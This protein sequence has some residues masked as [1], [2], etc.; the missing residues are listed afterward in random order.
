ML[1]A[2]VAYLASAALVDRRR[3]SCVADVRTPEEYAQ[4]KPFRGGYNARLRRTMRR[5]RR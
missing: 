4:V 3:R 5:G 2:L 1:R